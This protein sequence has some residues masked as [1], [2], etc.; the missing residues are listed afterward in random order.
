MERAHLHPMA[1]PVNV[2]THGHTWG[3]TAHE[4]WAHQ[5][6]MCYVLACIMM[7]QLAS[8]HPSIYDGTEGKQ[9]GPVVLSNYSLSPACMNTTV[10]VSELGAPWP[11]KLLWQPISMAILSLFGSL[12]DNGINPPFTV[13]VL[14]RRHTCMITSTAHEGII[15]AYVLGVHPEIIIKT[16]ALTRSVW[17]L[18]YAILLVLSAQWVGQQRSIQPSRYMHNVYTTGKVCELKLGKRI[19]PNLNQYRYVH[20]ELDTLTAV[21]KKQHIRTGAVIVL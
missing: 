21:H 9:Q 15:T 5:M 20:S 16:C 19:P 11:V 18:L 13:N 2:K 1:K 6:R 3:H 14:Y 8:L 17:H 4:T 10:S 7:P 12:D